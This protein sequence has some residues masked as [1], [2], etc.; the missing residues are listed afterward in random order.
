MTFSK[1]YRWLTQPVTILCLT[2]GVAFAAPDSMIDSSA[3]PITGSAAI[4][5]PGPELATS[6]AAAV[7]DTPVVL[8][9]APV[10]LEDTPVQS[11]DA[12]DTQADADTNTDTET[13]EVVAAEMPETQPAE[14]QPTDDLMVETPAAVETNQAEAE[15]ETAPVATSMASDK[16]LTPAIMPSKTLV[17]TPNSVEQIAPAMMD[18]EPSAS[19]AQPT[20]TEPTDTEIVAAP[21]PEPIP[22]EPLAVQI[23]SLKKQLIKLNRDLFILEEELLFPASTQVSV[24]LAVDADKTFILDSIKLK[25]DDKVVTEYLYTNRQTKALQR[26]GVQRLYMGNLRAGQHEVTAVFVGYGPDKREYKRAATLTFSKET[27]QKTIEL[28]ISAS[29]GNYQPQ[30]SVVES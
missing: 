12:T 25:I 20:D 14:I 2:T 18:S 3:E 24:L 30:F 26:G 13:A 8:E 23:E 4:S 17:A 22:E 6:N 1:S 19:E 28:K 15:A 7:L 16:P 21:E 9:D 11:D 10:A 29:D 5:V 27:G